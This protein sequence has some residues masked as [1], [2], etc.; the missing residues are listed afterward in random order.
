MVRHAGCGLLALAVLTACGGSSE[1]E[2]SK[3]ASGG[4]AGSGAAAGQGG[5]G[6]ATSGGSGGAAGSSVTG[7]A[8]GTTSSGGAPGC[9]LPAVAPGTTE[10]TVVSS[11]KDRKVRVHVPPGYD[12]TSDVP[13][14]M[15]FH[16]YTETAQQIENISQMTPVSDAHGFVVTYAQGISNSWNAGKCCGTA[17]AT[18]VPDVQFVSD[19][20]DAVSTD[21]CIDQK[22]VYAAGFSN[23]GMLS[24]RLACELSNRIAA[25]A[26]VSGPLAMDGCKPTRFMPMIEFHGTGDFVVPYNGG[27]I[28]GALSA[29]DNFDFWRTNA[30]CTDAPAEVYKNGD[31]TCVESSQCQGGTAVRL[32]TVQNGGHQWPGGQSA[33]PAGKLTQDIDASEEMAKFFLAHPLP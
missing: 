21:L 28:G 30:A 9:G 4:A 27:G 11:G 17:S 19:L 15:V 6:G 29:P 1:D 8:A 23:G 20:I 16:G 13:L 14:V 31:T 26:P 25:F 22:R 10:R 24:N 18:Q 5:A 33:G 7:G 3:P 32:C 2:L 12:A